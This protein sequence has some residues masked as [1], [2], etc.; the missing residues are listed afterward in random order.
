M[1]ALVAFGGIE[2]VIHYLPKP[3]R[4]GFAQHDVKNRMKRRF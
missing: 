4:G 1:F 3:K 2:H